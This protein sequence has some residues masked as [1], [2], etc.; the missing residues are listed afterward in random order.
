MGCIPMYGKYASDCN[1]NDFPFFTIYLQLKQSSIFKK[2][3]FKKQTCKILSKQKNK[4]C[5]HE[6]HLEM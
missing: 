5:L 6:K 1:L 2:S 4:N 3:F